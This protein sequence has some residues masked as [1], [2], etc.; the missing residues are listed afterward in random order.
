[1][2]K[3]YPTFLLFISF[4]LVFVTNQLFV[5]ITQFVNFKSGMLTPFSVWLLMAVA[6]ILTIAI[7]GT[8]L[9]IPVYF[10]RLNYLFKVDVKQR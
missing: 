4:T 6:S 10:D 5:D 1:M 7:A 8:I 3:S 9:I 2:E